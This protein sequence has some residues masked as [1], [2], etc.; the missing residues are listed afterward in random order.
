MDRNGYIGRAPADSSV[1]VAR[2]VFSPSGVTTDFT[3]TS[4]YTPG[5]LD[6]YLNGSRLVEGTDYT[7][8]DTS[9]ISVLN[10][11]ADGG[12][13][14]EAVAYKA[15]NAATATVGIS[16][17]G[18]SIS[19]Q[20]NTLN[21]IGTGNTFA[22][23][24]N[25]IDI[26]I[27]GSGGGSGVA[28]TITVADESSDTTCFPLFTTAATG[29]LAPKSGTNLTFNSSSGALTATSFVG[30]L[31]G[32]AT[33][34]TVADESSD[35]S[36]NV[37]F[38]TAATGDLA[39]KSGTNLT[40][41]SSS[42]A[43]TA[44]SFVG[45][46]TGNSAGSHTG[47]VDLNGGVLT[48][49][50]DADTTITADTDDQ[51]D[52]AFGGNDRITLS[53]GLID[54]KNDGSQSAIRLYCESSNAHYAALQAPAHSAFSGNITLTLPA[55]TDTLVGKT[56]TDTLTNKTLSAP[57]ITG[58]ASIADK[59]VHTGDTNTAI[60]FP[61]A[62]T[63]TV[64]TGGDEALRVDSSQRV[65]LGRTSNFTGTNAQYGLLQ[66]SGNSAG[67]TGDGRIVIGRGEVPSAGNQSLGQINFVDNTAGEYASIK[68]FTD[69]SC[70]T[71][72]YPGRIEFHTT[73]DAASSPVERLTITSDGK[74][75]LPDDGNLAFGADNDMLMRHSGNDAVIENTVGHIFISN[76]TDDEDIYLR[77]DDGSGGIAN[78]VECDGSS[79]KVKLYHYGTKK[80]E[81][82]SAGVEVDGK[83][84][85]TATD[86]PFLATTTLAGSGTV[87]RSAVQNAASSSN[88]HAYFTTSSGLSASIKTNGD[89]EFAGTVTDSIGPLRRLGQEI[90]SG[91][92]TLVAGDAGKHIRVDGN[93]TITVPDNVFTS[94]DM[95]TIV[96]NSSSTVAVNA[97]GSLTLYNA[98]DGTAGN[99]TMAARTV[100]TILIAEG[101][102]GSK[103]YISGGGLS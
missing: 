9:T 22:L 30:A 27:S 74:V 94:G 44:T 100:A 31:T 17:A 50:A 4:G 34:V 65:L 33:Q 3:F 89:A 15:F 67:A 19:T 29:D 39:P 79:G 38:T 98:S 61:A 40:F 70:G 10:G 35:T 36:C 54:L 78:Y 99:R 16:S 86:L 26:S 59:I 45:A 8:N 84:E 20:A 64:E 81:T 14:I 63:F 47:A 1:I 75:R 23:R 101:G 96:A 32:A 25:T 13:V 55:T 6:L 11:G 76:Y 73:A 80:F 53:T 87:F 37:L 77:T 85:S 68:A 58:D 21:F 62:D 2:Q 88:Y 46:L 56:T 41:N 7:A 91:D 24:G 72:D 90:K 57:S 92:Y 71:D 18:S 43:L 51:I 93:H 103:A 83:V 95:V 5:Y 102:S 42:G 60:R 69:G 48:L 49:D 97:S 82:T 66:I 28:S 52:I 12:D